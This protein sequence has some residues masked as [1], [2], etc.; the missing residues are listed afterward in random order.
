MSSV[1]NFYDLYSDYTASDLKASLFE[2]EKY[3]VSQRV[4]KALSE[5]YDKN[6]SIV[7]DQEL[8]VKLAE[9]LDLNLSPTKISWNYGDYDDLHWL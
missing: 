9:A 7:S 5:N 8:R 4:K 6:K 1:E 3:V 2:L